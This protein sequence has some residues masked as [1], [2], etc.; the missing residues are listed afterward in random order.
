MNIENV[1][2]CSVFELRQYLMRHGEFKSDYTGDITYEILLK[3]TVQIL[4]EQNCA[5]EAQYHEKLTKNDS[6][7]TLAMEKNARKAAALERS[8]QRQADPSYFEEKRNTNN[9]FEKNNLLGNNF[10]KND[11]KEDSEE[12][13]KSFEEMSIGK[14][15][16]DKNP[17]I[18]SFRSKIGGKHC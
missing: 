9:M 13:E 12:G 6:T 3:R 8:R 4:H 11:G 15:K 17:F 18:P 7:T 2:L 16:E 1:H 14:S 5:E 10:G